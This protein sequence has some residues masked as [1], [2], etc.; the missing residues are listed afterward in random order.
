M[1]NSRDSACDYN[2]KLSIDV[3][4]HI[5][6]YLE[7]VDN[8]EIVD[9]IE[10]YL[11]NSSGIKVRMILDIMGEKRLSEYFDIKLLN[12]KYKKCNRIIIEREPKHCFHTGLNLAEHAITLKI[13]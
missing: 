6:S 5:G 7:R 2:G 12:Q 3:P 11:I 1:I 10:N 13:K 8:P 4:Y 9:K